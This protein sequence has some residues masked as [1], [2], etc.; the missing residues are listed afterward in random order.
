M[1]KISL[2]VVIV[3]INMSTLLGQ[4]KMDEI[5]LN[6][7]TLIFSKSTQYAFETIDGK[8]TLVLNGRAEVKNAFFS[9]GTITVDVLANQKR[10]FAGI[11]FRKQDDTFEEVYIRMHK[12]GE[13]DALQYTPVFN[14]ESNWQLYPEYQTVAI[15]KNEGWN[16]LKIH[17]MDNVAEIFVNGKSML[18]VDDLKT[19]HKAGSIG[20]F[21]LFEN[22]FANLKFSENKKVINAKK[23][24]D[25]TIEGLITEWQLSDPK[26]Y[27]EV[28][29]FDKLLN[30]AHKKN[31]K[32][33]SNGLLLIS[34]YVV[35]PSRGMYERNSEDYVIVETSIDSNSEIIKSFSFDYSD[36]IIVYLNGELLY[37]GNNGFRFKNIQY[38]GHLK[39]DTNRIPLKLKK[40]KN[41]LQCIV[42]E[43]A[44]GWGL[45]GR[46]TDL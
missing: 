21:A 37:I 1:K 35:K 11:T 27:N 17:V 33:E 9:N 29:D 39:M 14:N 4:E 2:L 3:I 36:K 22:R 10:S 8:N 28:D 20:L 5:P 25:K 34:K 30:V 26:P 38:K 43:K 44:N 7:N 15:T 23:Q 19:D 13:P 42:V 18:I 31:V 40:G 41:L 16:T 45:M 6:E 24:D 12:S 32:T 46:V